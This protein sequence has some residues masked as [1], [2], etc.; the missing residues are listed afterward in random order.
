MFKNK[1]YIFLLAFFIIIIF[2][3]IILLISNC[4]DNFFNGS[5]YGLNNT[6]GKINTLIPLNNITKSTDF[7]LFSLLSQIK[8][9]FFKPPSEYEITGT[10]QGII[11]KTNHSFKNIILFPGQ[12]DYI[13]KQNNTEVW[14]K[15]FNNIDNSKN[16][17][18]YN[19][20]SGHFNTITTVLENLNYKN[21]DK[22]NTILY[23]FRNINFENVIK[24]FIN[25]INDNTI[26]IAY[27]FGA[28]MA[29]ICINSLPNN[30]YGINLK[31]KIDKLL[32]IC[33]TIGGTTMTLRDYFSGNGIINPELIKD[34]YSILLSM[35]NNLFYN[36][37][38]IIYNSLS[39]DANNI[40]ELFNVENKP[41]ELYNKLKYYNY[42]SLKNPGI[43]TIVITNN[44]YNT[45]VCYN[46]KNNL[47]NKPEMYY[48]KNNNQMPST[49]IQTNG[50]I[51]GLQSLGDK[52]VPI[53]SIYK[54]KELWGD[55]CSIEIIKDKDHFTIL[56]S[57]ELI[58][59]ILSNI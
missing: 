19:N 52:V 40:T 29:N 27:D 39:Y 1:S 48:P 43:N 49:N 20:N 30:N 58:L 35:P 4:S 7:K 26:I 23:D 42:L 28:I 41:S 5:G 15:N 46:F 16:S 18:V 38:V 53:N 12:T 47:K 9:K 59:I 54:L 6:F 8:F 17:E 2:I 50:L 45:P 13:L 25:F 57:Y 10:K 37:P 24:Q 3:F 55:N 51:E 34:Y 21:G 31:N 32:L 44:Q 56:K 36:Y 11:S 14:P 33:P 22:L